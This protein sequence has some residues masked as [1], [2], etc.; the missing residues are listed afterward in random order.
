MERDM[1]AGV[2]EGKRRR[3]EPNLPAMFDGA[4][5]AGMAEE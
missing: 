5:K 4:R 3:I 1:R 2:S